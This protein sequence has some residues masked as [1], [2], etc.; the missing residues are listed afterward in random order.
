LNS[1]L[2]VIGEDTGGGKLCGNLQPERG[3]K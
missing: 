2:L 1:G 3:Y